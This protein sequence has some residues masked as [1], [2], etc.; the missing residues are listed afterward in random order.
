[1]VPMCVSTCICRANYFGDIEDTDSLIHRVLKAHK[2][3]VLSEVKS[4]GETKLKN[5]DLKGKPPGAISSAVGYPGTLPV[6]S[7]KSKTKPR[8]FYIVP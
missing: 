6:F 1:M 8:V 7:D 3:M 5:Q 2:T 4:P